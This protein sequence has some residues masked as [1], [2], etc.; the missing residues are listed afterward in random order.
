MRIHLSFI[1]TVFFIILLSSAAFNSPP[2]FNYFD[3]ATVTTQ[4]GLLNVTPLSLPLPHLHHA[5]VTLDQPLLSF[6][7]VYFQGRIDGLK[8]GGN[9]VERQRRE[10]LGSE[11]VE[12]LEAGAEPDSAE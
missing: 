11:G 1:I 7:L 10:I 9:Y 3:F 8:R 12:T 2:L 5:F 6:F 4:F